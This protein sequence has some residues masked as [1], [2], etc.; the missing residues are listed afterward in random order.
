MH[1]YVEIFYLQGVQHSTCK[2]FLLESLRNGELFDSS[3]TNI[4]HPNLIYKCHTTIAKKNPGIL[5]YLTKYLARQETIY[6]SNSG[7]YKKMVGAQVIF[8]RNVVEI[9]KKNHEKY[10]NYQYLKINKSIFLTAIL[11]K[12]DYFLL[13]LT[14]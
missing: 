9:R 12:L 8:D 13:L 7:T 2:M 6:F 10:E 11:F 4:R 14:I 5:K 1:M 3:C